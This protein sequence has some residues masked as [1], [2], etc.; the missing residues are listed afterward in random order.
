M[1]HTHALARMMNDMPQ[2]ELR[3][4]IEAERKLIGDGSNA[5]IEVEAI[6]IEADPP[7]DT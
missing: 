7:A 2:D 3:A 6:P 5:S 4:L 1:H